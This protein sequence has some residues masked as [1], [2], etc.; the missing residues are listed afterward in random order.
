MYSYLLDHTDAETA[1]EIVSQVYH[2]ENLNR[3]FV[4]DY[5]AYFRNSRFSGVSLESFVPDVDPPPEVQRELERL[6]PGR[7]QFSKI[8]ILARCHKA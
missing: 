7:Q 6:H 3:L 1:G 8:G 5:E 4:E 2:S